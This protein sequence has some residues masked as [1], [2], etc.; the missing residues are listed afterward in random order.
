M[1]SPLPRLALK[2][3]T[4]AAL[5]TKTCHVVVYGRWMSI[6]TRPTTP[7]TWLT[8]DATR[9]PIMILTGCWLREPLT[10][11]G[12]THLSGECQ[13]SSK[14]KIFYICSAI[15]RCV[16][17]CT[18]GDFDYAGLQY[19]SQCICTNTGPDGESSEG[20]CTYG[21]AGDDSVKMCGG[22]GYINI[23]HT[24]AH[25]TTIDDWGC[26]NTV[27]DLYY[28]KW[29]DDM[30]HCGKTG[31][32]ATKVIVLDNMHNVIT[33]D[34]PAVTATTTTTTPTTSPITTG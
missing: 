31:K 4:W 11:S 14:P 13:W 26:G 3:A 6:R 15:F 19:G 16:N 10:I 29:Y 1:N 5:G 20:H 33:G 17:F 30:G 32:K 28:Q 9:T 21:C 22:L 2:T 12:T 8:S 7:P 23:F 34:G 24:D 25:K 27:Q 18:N